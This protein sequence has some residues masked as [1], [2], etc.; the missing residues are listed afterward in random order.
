MPS[1]TE[2]KAMKDVGTIKQQCTMFRPMSNARTT[3]SLKYNKMIKIDIKQRFNSKYNQEKN[4]AKMFKG[5][6]QN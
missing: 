2:G 3:T 5:F 6:V 4:E 1:K